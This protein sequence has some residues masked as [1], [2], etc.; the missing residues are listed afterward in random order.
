MTDDYVNSFGHFLLVDRINTR[1][2]TVQMAGSTL[3]MDK[4]P[5]TDFVRAW[6]GQAEPASIPG[7]WSAFLKNEPADN[8]AL[9]IKRAR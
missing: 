3:G 6:S 2:K 9:I 5:L 8:W 4:V 1:T 7:G